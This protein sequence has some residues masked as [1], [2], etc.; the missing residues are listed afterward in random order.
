MEE[1][2]EIIKCEIRSLDPL[3]KTMIMYLYK[4]SKPTSMILCDYGLKIVD[5][6]VSDI[7]LTF[8]IPFN[9]KIK[10]NYD[11]NE[12]TAFRTNHNNL[13]NGVWHSDSCD[14]SF[15]S[16][17]TT[18]IETNNYDNLNKLMT[19][20]IN[21]DAKPESKEERKYIN[22]YVYESYEYWTYIGTQKKR[23]LDSIILNDEIKKSIINDINKFINDESLYDKLNIPYKRNYLFYGVPGTGKTSFV[24]AIASYINYDIYIAKLSTKKKT[25]E[26]LVSKVKD[27]SVLL[28][29]DI[30][31]CFPTD[32]KDCD[33][34]EINDL[35]NMLD[36]ISHKKIIIIMSANCVDRIPKKLLRPGRV[37]MKI[38][39]TYCKKPE[40]I[41][42]FNRFC[43][44][45]DAD[46]FYNT[47]KHIP[48]LTPAILQEFLFRKNPEERTIKILN[49]LVNF[50][51]ETKQ[52]YI[53]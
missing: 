14:S 22:L 44:D 15:N 30:E 5:S 51:K 26:D 21:D 43:P 40:I 34:F 32:L 31:H 20:I 52:T 27:N 12:Y 13:T 9:E 42:L 23:S 7:K 24:H 1:K 33:K 10:F 35:L 25:F 18:V 50:S 49:E 53:E 41:K 8:E 19:Y 28:I 39:F 16:Y 11:G 4:L 45:E 3:Y 48:I 2:Q 47:V 6:C 38:E 29:E 36:G 17:E 46:K 37:D